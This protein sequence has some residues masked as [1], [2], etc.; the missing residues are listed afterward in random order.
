MDI[1]G[2]L[3]DKWAAAELPLVSPDWLIRFSLAYGGKVVVTSPESVA[4][5]VRQRAESAL[6]KYV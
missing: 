3:P 2:E 5:A 6:Q 1:V 4:T